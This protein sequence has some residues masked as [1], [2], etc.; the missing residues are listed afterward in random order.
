MIRGGWIV[1]PALIASV[2]VAL[3]G[4]DAA[5][6]PGS[7]GAST[8][9]TTQPEASEAATSQPPGTPVV[10]PG[11]GGDL[12]G[13]VGE[14]SDGVIFIDWTEAE[15]TLSGTLTQFYVTP[16]STSG[17]QQS[18]AISGLRSGDDV[19]LRLSVPLGSDQTWTGRLHSGGLTLSFPLESG[20][21]SVAELRDG[22]VADYNAAVAGWQT[23]LASEAEQQAAQAALDKRVT[24]AADTLERALGALTADLN[25]AQN[26]AERA[27][28]RSGGRDSYAR[29][30]P[31][32]P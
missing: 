30:R 9:A 28:S 7:P 4:C 32:R 22:S 20:G 13:Y 23:R 8:T 12:V 2:V 10:E 17:R 24:D 29:R 31:Q 18:S 14:F 19:T 21:F 6:N 27:S 1:W 25:T 16:G 3:A 5:G 26:Y 11:A 15:G